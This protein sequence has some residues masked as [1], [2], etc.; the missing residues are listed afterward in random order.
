MG[1]DTALWQQSV[2][3][4]HQQQISNFES[5]ASE[6]EGKVSQASDFWWFWARETV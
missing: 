1:A 5:F 6:L 3:L 2:P 4:Q